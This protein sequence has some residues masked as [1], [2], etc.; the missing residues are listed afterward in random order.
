MSHLDPRPVDRLRTCAHA[1]LDRVPG[2]T[3]SRGLRW[4]WSRSHRGRESQSPRQAEIT[5]LAAGL[6][7]SAASI[8]AAVYQ[9][10]F[11]DFDL[12]V[13]CH[14]LSPKQTNS[15]TAAIQAYGC[16]VRILSVAPPR[17]GSATNLGELLRD[18]EVALRRSANPY[19]L[20]AGDTVGRSPMAGR[21]DL[22]SYVVADP[23]CIALRHR[24]L[25]SSELQCSR[26]GQLRGFQYLR[27]GY[28]GC[29]G[30]RKPSE[31]SP[32]NPENAGDGP[33]GSPDSLLM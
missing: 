17:D 15:L 11:G 22:V 24:D 14:T 16:Y 25:E 23:E 10:L 7:E 4:L 13:L 33:E 27:D 26:K 1:F 20:T 8:T 6:L 30:R 2:Y 28:R 12:V 3:Y 29:C 9:F 31:Q 21:R 32:C 18:V 19:T 5:V